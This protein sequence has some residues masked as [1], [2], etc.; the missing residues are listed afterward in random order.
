L[1]GISTKLINSKN[2]IETLQVK[3]STGT[4]E[5]SLNE[6]TKSINEL[7]DKADRLNRKVMG[8]SDDIIG[9]KGG[10]NRIRLIVEY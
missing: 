10:V 3:I 8:I 1:E 9:I 5:K 6:V 4:S 2:N 7:S